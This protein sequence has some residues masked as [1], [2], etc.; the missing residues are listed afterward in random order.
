MNPTSNFLSSYM[1]HVEQHI[2][3]NKCFRVIWFVN[4]ITINVIVD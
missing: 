2:E 3:L 1:Y 4:E